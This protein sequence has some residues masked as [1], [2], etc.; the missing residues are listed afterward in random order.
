[1]ERKIGNEFMSDIIE[2]KISELKLLKTKHEN[3]TNEISY[4]KNKINKKNLSNKNE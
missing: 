3:L 4:L 2:K 1:M